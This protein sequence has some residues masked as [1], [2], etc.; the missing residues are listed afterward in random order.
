MQREGFDVRPGEVDVEEKEEN[1]K[2]G[3][4]WLRGG[5]GAVSEGE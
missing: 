5:G 4:G 1:P 2:A 3:Y